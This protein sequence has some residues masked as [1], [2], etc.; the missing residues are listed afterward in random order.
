MSKKEEI[1]KL[2]EEKLPRA[3]W[4]WLAAL[5]ALFVLFLLTEPF[6]RQ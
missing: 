6:Y 5:G 4:W 3:F 2:E 1:E